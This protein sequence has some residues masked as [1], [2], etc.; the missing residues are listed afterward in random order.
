[1]SCSL[2]LPVQWSEIWKELKKKKK[3]TNIEPVSFF[4]AVYTLF[5]YAFFFFLFS[6]V[7]LFWLL[8]R[9]DFH[10]LPLCLIVWFP[11]IAK[12]TIHL[13]VQTNLNTHHHGLRGNV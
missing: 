12:I 2:C 5:K 13:S 3:R 9:K 11:A 10:Q 7:L 6:K 4:S 1:M 8:N